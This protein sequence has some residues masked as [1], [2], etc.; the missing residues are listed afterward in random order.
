MG[1]LASLVLLALTFRNRPVI[2]T[3]IFCILLGLSVLYV[4]EVSA[5]LEYFSK[6]FVVVAVVLLK[7]LP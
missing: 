4:L 6:S 2:K 5:I 1:Q 3:H 7:V